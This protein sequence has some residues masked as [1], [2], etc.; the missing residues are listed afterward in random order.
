MNKKTI[1]LL[2]AI[3]LIIPIGIYLFLMLAK[4]DKLVSNVVVNSNIASSSNNTSDISKVEPATSTSSNNNPVESI[5]VAPTDFG[6]SYNDSAWQKTD[7]QGVYVNKSGA[8][9]VYKFVQAEFVDTDKD[10]LAD[11]DEIN[12]YHTNPNNADTDS[13]GLNDGAEVNVWGSNP[14]KADTNGDGINDGDSVKQEIN[15]VTGKS[16]KK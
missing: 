14:N 6:S 7:K 2:V 10:G 13:D 9:P 16:F 5:V 8:Y 1:I 4:T 12:I 11:Q 15:P 3:L